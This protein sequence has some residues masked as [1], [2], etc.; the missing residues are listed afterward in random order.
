MKGLYS[1]VISGKFEPVTSLY[2]IDL[3]NMVKSCLQ[4][5]ASL[6]PNCDKIL[7]MPGL[8][9]HLTGTLDEIEALKLETESLLK[10]I[11]MPIR[12]Q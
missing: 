3:R 9:N 6:R 10:T 11:R 7:A 4:T 2:S 12:L 1:K 8:L 5:R